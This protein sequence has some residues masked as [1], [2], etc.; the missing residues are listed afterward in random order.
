LKDKLT[1]GVLAGVAHI[2]RDDGTP[3]MM[4]FAA[5]K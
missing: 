4:R 2:L 1:S 5:A 3:A